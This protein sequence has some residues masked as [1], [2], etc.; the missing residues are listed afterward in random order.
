MGR[1]IV[2]P[3]LVS[4]TSKSDPATN[5][6][7]TNGSLCDRIVAIVGPIVAHNGEFCGLIYLFD[8][9]HTSLVS[10]LSKMMSPKNKTKICQTTCTGG[11]QSASF[12]LTET[13]L[14]EVFRRTRDR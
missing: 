6:V 4:P 14:R 13:S 12:S 2:T 10:A 9:V 7:E 3:M 1:L 5:L 8:C 11:G